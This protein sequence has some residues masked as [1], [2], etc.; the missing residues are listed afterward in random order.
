MNEPQLQ[1]AAAGSDGFCA[2]RVIILILWICTI[3]APNWA[4]AE[5]Q[6]I[7][8]YVWQANVEGFGGFSGLELSPDGRRFTTISDQSRL[9]QGTIERNEAGQIIGITTAGWGWL[10]DPVGTRLGKN[11]RDAE[12]LAQRADGRLYVSFEGR[13]P[14]IWTYR[15]LG[16][17]AAWLP[18]A[19][20]FDLLQR[21]SGLEALAI[22]ETG[23]LYAMPE[24]SGQLTRP[25]PVWRYR[26]GVWEQPFSIPRRDYLLPVGMD[27]GPDGKMYI[28][29]RHF[30]G[31]SFENR[32]RRFTASS[33]GLTNEETVL[34]PGRGTHANL[35][36]LAIWRDT[37]GDLIATMIADN[38]FRSFLPTEIVEYRLP[39]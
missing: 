11:M 14:R 10:T 24:R 13:T 27:F 9:V 30:S 7:S 36:G 33:N 1:R 6:L 31:L 12:G 20:A 28:L 38:N 2:G 26:S 15:G 17:E 19:D 35:E 34:R 8:R 23:A 39:D 18:R 25:F 16:S 4:L 22:D 5:A 37:S 29:E 3:L 32:V 21:N